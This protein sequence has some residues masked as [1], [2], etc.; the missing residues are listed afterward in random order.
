MIPENFIVFYEGEDSIIE[1]PYFCMTEKEALK[2][3]EKWKKQ[4]PTDASHIYIAK[5]IKKP[6]EA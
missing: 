6:K 5:I 3:Y 2:Q 1:A 4:F